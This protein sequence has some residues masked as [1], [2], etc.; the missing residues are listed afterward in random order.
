MRGVTKLHQAEFTV[1]SELAKDRLIRLVAAP[2]LFLVSHIAQSAISLCISV[3]NVYDHV[4]KTYAPN[5]RVA[6]KRNQLSE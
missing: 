2:G 4:G 5:V 3:G 6:L 1:R